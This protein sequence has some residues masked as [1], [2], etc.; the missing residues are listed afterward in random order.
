MCCCP[1]PSKPIRSPARTHRCLH[2]GDLSSAPLMTAMAHSSPLRAPRVG[3]EVEDTGVSSC[4]TRC[5]AEEL[6]MLRIRIIVR[7][8]SGRCHIEGA[9]SSWDVR[10]VTFSGLDRRVRRV[11][12]EPRSLESSILGS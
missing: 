6:K 3:R 11:V 1:R 2:L 4:R 12:A 10:S 7:K 8:P 9:E 5:M